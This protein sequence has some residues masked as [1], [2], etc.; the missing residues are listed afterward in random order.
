MHLV[1]AGRAVPILAHDEPTDSQQ[2]RLL[3]AS[4]A[5]RLFEVQ[6]RL[7]VGVLGAGGA[8][9]EGFDGEQLQAGVT[10]V[11]ALQFF[12]AFIGSCE[13]CETFLS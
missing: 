4:L 9:E 11:F 12:V 3:R 2:L 8:G 10:L 6:I 5:L 1:G 7:V 13:I